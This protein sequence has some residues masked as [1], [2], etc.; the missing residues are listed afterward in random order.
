MDPDARRHFSLPQLFS[1][2]ELAAHSE[3]IPPP[4]PIESSKNQCPKTPPMA[5][6]YNEYE[7]NPTVLTAEDP[8]M[9]QHDYD[10]ANDQGHVQGSPAPPKTHLEFIA[11]HFLNACG[12]QKPGEY[13]MI[14]IVRLDIW[15]W[16]EPWANNQYLLYTLFCLEDELGISM[17]QPVDFS[18]HEKEMSRPDYDPETRVNHKFKEI[19]NAAIQY[20]K[21]HPDMK[22]KYTC[23]A[24]IRYPTIPHRFGSREVDI[25]PMLS[26]QYKFDISERGKPEGQ[27]RQPGEASSSTAEASAS[28]A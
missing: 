10:A 5:E 3:R 18:E 2:E 19:Y 1:E 13:R 20:Y 24:I 21:D 22:T 16:D 9:N 7:W 17:L 27:S 25:A 6:Q 8:V 4:F 11:Q 28:R 14:G 26:E 23:S 15:P 12:I